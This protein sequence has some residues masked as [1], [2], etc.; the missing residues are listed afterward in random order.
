MANRKLSQVL[1]ESQT[2]RKQIQG[3]MVDIAAT[4]ISEIVGYCAMGALYC[5][6]GLLQD[7]KDKGRIVYPTEKAMIEYFMGE[8]GYSAV[9]VPVDCNF[10]KDVTDPLRTYNRARQF[11]TGWITSY[12]IHMNDF[13][14]M[15]FEQ[16]GKELERLGF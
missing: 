7:S 12:M 3:S 16:I 5:E 13:H 15:T 14:K 9:Q 11:S 10:C 8:G 2:T 6:S 1:I 4:K